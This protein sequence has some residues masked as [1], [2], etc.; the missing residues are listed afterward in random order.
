MNDLV[1]EFHQVHMRDVEDSHCAQCQLNRLSTVR[2]IPRAQLPP[3][4]SQRTEHAR[5]VETLPFAMFAVI[6][7]GSASHN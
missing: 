6:H 7:D 2:P 4:L 5:P 1:V 3:D